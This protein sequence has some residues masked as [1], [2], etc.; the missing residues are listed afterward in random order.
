V[1]NITDDSKMIYSNNINMFLLSKPPSKSFTKETM[2]CQEP[3]A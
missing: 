2:K 3:R 1:T